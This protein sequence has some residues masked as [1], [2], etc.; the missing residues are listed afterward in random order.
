MYTYLTNCVS[1]KGEDIQDMLDEAI[2]V[3]YRE[4]EHNIGI[5]VLLEMFGNDVP[6]SKDWH[7]S[8]WRSKYMGVDCYYIDHS[9]IE[10]IFTKD[11]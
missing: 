7:V 2:E 11:A 5:D 9:R 6:L 8:F 4:F 10:Y 3:K 1:A